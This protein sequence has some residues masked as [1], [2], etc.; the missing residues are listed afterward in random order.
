MAD[1][2]KR[3]ATGSGREALGKA[4]GTARR[5]GQ[6]A[7]GTVEDVT[8]KAGDVTGKAGDVTGKAG[9]VTGKAGDVTGK[10]GDVTGKAG[11]VT[12]KAGDVAGKAGEAGQGI[13][14][15]LPMDRLVQSA[16]GLLQAAGTRVLSSAGDKLEGLTGR[17]TDYVEHGGKGLMSAVTGSD[18]PGFMSGALKG[19][20][21]GGLKGGIKG[22]L[23]GGLKG[24]WQKITGR[25]GGKAGHAKITNIVESIDIGAPRR[26]VYDQWTQFQDFPTFMKKV[27]TINQESDE[28]L[29][30]KAQVFWSHRTWKA[31]IIEQIPDQRIIWRSE[32]AKGYVDGAVTFHEVSP[33]LTRVLVVLEYHPQGL[34]ERTGNLWRA[35]GRRVRLELKHFRRHVMAHLLLKPDE[36][37]GWRGEIRD[38]QVVKDHETAVQEERE[39]QEAEEQQPE[40]GERAEAEE[41]EEGERAE[42]E[43]P[44]EGERAEAEEPEEEYE[45]EPEEEE[46]EEEEEPEEEEEEPEEEEGEFEEE[47]GEFEE[48]EEEE[49]GEEEEEEEPEERP[50]APAVARRRAGAPTRRSAEHDRP[51]RRRRI[52]AE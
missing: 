3:T 18:K 43:E 22:G 9:D 16:Q 1:A 11:D 19:G 35:Q 8:G 41:P 29:S 28:E 12:G 46:E 2:A 31:H 5:A 17:L 10:A 36:L 4:A 47:E 30:W 48:P 50:A 38:S 40:E 49:E 24:I 51:V 25:G 39:Q 32:G 33:D 45:E 26:L 14:D 44:E 20:L 13:A 21:T 15:N 52:R 42:A 27:E 7:T 23:K 34:F 6:A 37:E